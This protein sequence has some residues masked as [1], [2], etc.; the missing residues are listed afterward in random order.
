[1]N[2]FVLQDVDVFYNT[3]DIISQSFLNYTVLFFN[4][5]LYKWL[6]ISLRYC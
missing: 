3:K 5:I 1:V 4:Y 6:S 2:V